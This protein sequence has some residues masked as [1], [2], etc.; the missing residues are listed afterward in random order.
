MKKRER[1]ETSRKIKLGLKERLKVVVEVNLLD[2]EKGVKWRLKS[3]DNEEG[4]YRWSHLSLLLS[5]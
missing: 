3:E 1:K 4:I 2:Y 5:V